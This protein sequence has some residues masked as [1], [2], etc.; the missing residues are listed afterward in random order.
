MG[1]ISWAERARR[2]ERVGWVGGFRG[3]VFLRFLMSV[4][5]RFHLEGRF[6][7]CSR[8]LFAKSILPNW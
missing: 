7:D 6:A 4:P 5:W 1:G 2:V 8:I 3:M